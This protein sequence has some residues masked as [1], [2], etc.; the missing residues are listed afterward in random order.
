VQSYRSESDK[1]RTKGVVL[2]ASSCSDMFM[3]TADVKHKLLKAI[4][5]VEDLF[6]EYSNDTIE[7]VVNDLHA[8]MERASSVSKV[9][10]KE[11]TLVQ[12]Q[13]PNR[14]MFEVKPSLQY[15]VSLLLNDISNFANLYR[16]FRDSQFEFFDL[17]HEESEL[18]RN[19]ADQSSFV[20]RVPCDPQLSKDFYILQLIDE[21][22][23]SGDSH[24]LDKLM[25][26]FEEDSSQTSEEEVQHFA[27]KV[28][29]NVIEEEDAE[30]ESA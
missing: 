4:H 5:E 26:E 10:L 25:R 7:R 3:P 9:R 30:S 27:P 12:K 29:I 23:F 1:G 24:L 20:E 28:E 18:G 15:V 11:T 16:T 6:I 17:E 8:Q 22:R 2:S 19:G 14:S 13:R 21:F